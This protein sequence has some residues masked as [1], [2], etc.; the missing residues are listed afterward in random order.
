MEIVM[1][2]KKCGKEAPIN[3]E[4][5]NKNWIVYDNKPCECGGEYTMKLVK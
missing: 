4:K 2:C 3:K 5:S 1:V